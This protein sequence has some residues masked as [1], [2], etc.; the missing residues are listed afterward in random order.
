MTSTQAL[1][2]QWCTLPLAQGCC[3]GAYLA[4]F[5]QHTSKQPCATWAIDLHSCLISSVLRY[6]LAAATTFT[7][8]PI[9]ETN[10]GEHLYC[11]L[12]S[13]HEIRPWHRTDLKHLT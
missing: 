3:I 4:P 6:L 1:G 2:R 13:Q 11:V 12:C 9:C 8:Q 5:C 7:E 10:A